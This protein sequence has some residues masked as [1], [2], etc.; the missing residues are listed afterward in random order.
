VIRFE[1]LAAHLPLA[2]DDWQLLCGC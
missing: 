2:D 1:V